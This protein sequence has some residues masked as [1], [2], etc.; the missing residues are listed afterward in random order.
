[1]P[2]TWHCSTNVHNIYITLSRL[3]SID[4][5]IILQDLTIKVISKFEFKKWLIKM[6]TPSSKHDITKKNIVLNSTHWNA[7]IKI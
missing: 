5:L 4:G 2:T 3:H 7:T 6:V 1:L